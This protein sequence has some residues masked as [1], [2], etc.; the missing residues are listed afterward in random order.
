MRIFTGHRLYTAPCHI[1]HVEFRPKGGLEDALHFTLPDRT[2]SFTK[3]LIITFIFQLSIEDQCD[4]D[5]IYSF[6]RW[7]D[8]DLERI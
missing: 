4:L 2:F 8:S 5:D 1:G 7:E 3:E 6:N